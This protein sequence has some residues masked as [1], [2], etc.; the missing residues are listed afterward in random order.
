MRRMGEGALSNQ[1]EPSEQKN[2]V[3]KRR[4]VFRERHPGQ[5]SRTTG[6]SEREE[7]TELGFWLGQRVRAGRW[8]VLRRGV[9]WPALFRTG[10]SGHSL[11]GQAGVE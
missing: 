5:C 4:R 6:P 9:S 7:G 11:K 3:L 2:R 10:G 8:G 1:K